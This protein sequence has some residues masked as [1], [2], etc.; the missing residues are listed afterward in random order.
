MRVIKYKHIFLITE[1][2]D[3]VY[4]SFLPVVTSMLKL[5][6]KSKKNVF[7]FTTWNAYCMK[8]MYLLL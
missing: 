8:P 3:N 4:M 1:L 2:T 7:L 6:L 5:E